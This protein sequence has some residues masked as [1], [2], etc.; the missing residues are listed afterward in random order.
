MVHR[1][2]SLQMVDP[3]CVCTAICSVCE[4]SSQQSI[5]VSQSM[6]RIQM[7]FDLYGWYFSHLRTLKVTVL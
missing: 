7:R 4:L 6:N 3:F 5:S 1:L 2:K